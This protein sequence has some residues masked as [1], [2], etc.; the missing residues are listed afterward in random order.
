MQLPKPL[1]NRKEK[2]QFLALIRRIR[3][4]G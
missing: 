2:Q 3:N 1:L 4:E